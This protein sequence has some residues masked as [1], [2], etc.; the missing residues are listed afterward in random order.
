MRIIKSGIITKDEVWQGNIRVVGDVV[1]E[2]NV[3]VKVSPATRITFAE[4]SG[5]NCEEKFFTIRFINREC[6]V[7]C[8]E[9]CF[10]LVKG[11]LICNGEK[12]KKIYIGNKNWD[13]GIIVAGSTYIK[14][15]LNFKKR[16]QIVKKTFIRIVPLKIYPYL[17]L[18]HTEVSG[19]SAGVYIHFF[20][21]M[22]S[23]DSV[24]QRCKFG[25]IFSGTIFLLKNNILRNNDTG[26]FM[27]GAG[28]V[29]ITQNLIEKNMKF[30]IFSRRG[31]GFNMGK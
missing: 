14:E 13:G 26:L 29:K 21:L 16:R 1:I 3:T 24:F 2:E 19:A 7:N 27:P 8:E 10:I 20:S 30:G 28:L 5:Y 9:K 4:K 25:I 17:S 18:K 31:Y 22:S 15:T 12:R 6:D 11:K 23:S